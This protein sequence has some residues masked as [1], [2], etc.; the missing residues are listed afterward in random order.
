MMRDPRDLLKIKKDIQILLYKTFEE[1]QIITV[2][3]QRTWCVVWTFLLFSW[4]MRLHT[5][6][7]YFRLWPRR[8]TCDNSYCSKCGSH[9]FSLLLP[10]GIKHGE[11][12]M[13]TRVPRAQHP[14]KGALAAFWHYV[15]II[16]EW[17]CHYVWIIW[18][19]G[20]K[21][22]PDKLD[23]LGPHLN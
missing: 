16:W 14:V 11:R 22:N 21:E 8:L 15:W 4:Q 6:V 3:L 18:E 13:K 1:T 12:R 17:R 19:W 5:Y 9:A 23:I 7:V 20:G 2:W 10:H